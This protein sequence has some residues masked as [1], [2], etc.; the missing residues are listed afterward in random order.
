MPPRKSRFSVSRT[1]TGSAA[2]LLGLSGLFA[3]GCSGD[4]RVESGPRLDAGEIEAI[5][6][7][8]KGDRE[9]GTAVIAKLME[10]E[11]LIDESEPTPKEKTARKRKSR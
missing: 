6:K 1:G 7:K 3:V 10:K 2:I 4:A 8:T 11:G 5:R 9:F